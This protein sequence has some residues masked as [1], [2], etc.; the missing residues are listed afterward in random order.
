MSFKVE[1][2]D[3][4]DNDKWIGNGMRFATKREAQAWASCL[5]GSWFSGTRVKYSTDPINY[6]PPDIDEEGG[7]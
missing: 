1:I 3:K 4:S 7:D 2:Q 6:P 5:Y